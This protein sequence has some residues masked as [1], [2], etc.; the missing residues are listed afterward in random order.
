MAVDEA[1]EDAV[2]RP[3]QAFVAGQRAGEECDE[4][5]AGQDGGAERDEH[6]D[7][8]R[9]AP[10]RES[11][12]NSPRAR[13]SRTKAAPQTMNDGSDSTQKPSAAPSTSKASSSPR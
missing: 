9:T 5:P 6:G 13:S 2:G 3:Q 7:A 4:A 8:R 1:A 10:R 12:E 11:A